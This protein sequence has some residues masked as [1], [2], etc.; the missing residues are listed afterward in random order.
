MLP[1]HAPD[2]IAVLSINDAAQKAGVSRRTIYHWMKQDKIACVKTAGGQI[3]IVEASLW[4]QKSGEHWTQGGVTPSV[5]RNT[6]TTLSVAQKGQNDD[7]PPQ[8]R[9]L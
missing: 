6:T 2:A 1:P 7:S 5:T 3:R 4:R 9:L 8:R